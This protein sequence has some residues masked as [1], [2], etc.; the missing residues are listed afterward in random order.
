[1]LQASLGAMLEPVGVVSTRCGRI[2]LSCS[3]A[4]EFDTVRIPWIGIFPGS[5]AG[6]YMDQTSN[7]SCALK[8]RHLINVGNVKLLLALKN[9]VKFS[10]ASLR[11]HVA[12]WKRL[13]RR[14]LSAT[15]R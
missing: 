8:S 3:L 7:V 9:L 10:L 2:R 5:K 12:L 1:V 15:V 13:G 6:A 14:A 4:F 11:G